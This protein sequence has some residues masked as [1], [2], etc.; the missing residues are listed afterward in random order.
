MQ[1]DNNCDGSVDEGF[2]GD[3]DGYTTCGGDCAPGDAAVNPGAAEVCDGVDN[4][5]TGRLTPLQ[6]AVCCR[7]GLLV[8]LIRIVPQINAKAR[9]DQRHVNDE[10]HA[11][12]AKKPET[13]EE[14]PPV[15]FEHVIH[16][17]SHTPTTVIR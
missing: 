7:K 10:R 14:S 4:I 1:L 6:S 9:R 2:D 11:L 8:R 13:G 15:C 3:G 17:R 12:L 16:R 5:V